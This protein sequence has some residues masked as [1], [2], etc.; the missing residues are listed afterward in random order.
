MAEKRLAKIEVT[1][2]SDNA[3][4]DNLDFNIVKQ[5]FQPQYVVFEP[6]PGPQTEFL[7]APEREVLFGGAA[8]GSKT[9]SLI[10]DPLRYFETQTS[11]VCYCGE[12]MTSCEKSCGHVRNSTRKRTRERNGR[13]RR[14]NG[15]SH[16]VQD[17][18]LLTWKD[19]RMF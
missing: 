1:N 14:R 9:Y 18:G 12:P 15:R 17:F 19:R 6:L 8:G 3:V 7:A 11:T 10:A 5:I 13:R 2:A 16:L 4:T